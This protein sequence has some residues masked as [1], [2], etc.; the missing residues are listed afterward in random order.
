MAKGD[1]LLQRIADDVLIGPRTRV[2]AFVNLYKCTIGTD[3]MIGTFVEIQDATIG[4]HVRVQSHSFIC[5][6]VEIEDYVFIGHGVMFGNDKHPSV[7]KTEMGSWELEKVL[8]RTGASIGSGAIIMPGVT[9]G[10]CAM[11]G[12]GAVVTKD[13][14]D[15]AT[16]MGVPARVRK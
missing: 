15:G 14:P 9:I 7:M 11:V 3:C 4:N 10:K 8:V 2:G 16:V 6:G 5:S 12:A 13:V 1:D